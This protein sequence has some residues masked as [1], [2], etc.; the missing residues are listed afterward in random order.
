MIRPTIFERRENGGARAD[1]DVRFAVADAPPFAGALDIRQAAVQHGDAFAKSRANQ[2]ADP[3]R[4]RD[5]GNEDDGRLSA[6]ERRFDR[7]EIHFRLAAA[8]DA[9]KKAGRKF[10]RYEP[11]PDFFERVFLFGVQHIR[12]RGEIRV[13]GIFV[14]RERLFPGEQAAFFLEAQNHGARNACFRGEDCERER[15]A[16]GCEDFFDFFLRVIFRRGRFVRGRICLRR[17]PGQN[18]LRAGAAFP[19]D[20]ASAEVAAANE[21]FGG[22]FS[23]GPAANLSG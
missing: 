1:D 23:A 21:T 7:A 5:F 17:I 15:P 3:Q 6:R 18:F 12:G 11:A 4:E 13:P 22:R 2:A 10:A 14:G 20:F 19:K 9:V 8:G 16:H